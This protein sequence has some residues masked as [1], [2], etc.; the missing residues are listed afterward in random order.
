MAKWALIRCE[1]ATPFN[2]FQAICSVTQKVL[3]ALGL[4]VQLVDR[5]SLCVQSLTL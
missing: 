3:K 4:P 1:I 2:L 5:A